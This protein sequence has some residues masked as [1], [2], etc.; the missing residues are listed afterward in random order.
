M[1]E[2]IYFFYID[3]ISKKDDKVLTLVEEVKKLSNEIKELKGIDTFV[4]QIMFKFAYI[5][6]IFIL[7]AKR[8]YC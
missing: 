7:N 2:K 1:T 3:I 5:S 4:F 8:F 6:I